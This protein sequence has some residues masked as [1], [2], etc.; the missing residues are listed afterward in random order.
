MG[1]SVF[2]SG[3]YILAI[4]Q[5]IKGCFHEKS[6]YL[7]NAMFASFK[8]S[9]KTLLISSYLQYLN[10]LWRTVTLYFQLSD[11]NIDLFCG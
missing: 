10:C 4:I 5:N 2:H 3:I 1:V 7:H 6:I 11:Y 9:I 8:E